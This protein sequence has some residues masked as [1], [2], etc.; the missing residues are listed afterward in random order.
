MIYV[1]T[2]DPARVGPFCAV[3]QEHLYAYA[4]IRINGGQTQVWTVVKKGR[5]RPAACDVLEQIAQSLDI[6]AQVWRGPLHFPE[7]EQGMKVLGSPWGSFIQQFL[8]MKH[9]TLLDRIPQLPDVQSAWS[10]LQLCVCESQ[11]P[12]RLFSPKQ[13]PSLPICTI[14]GSGIVCVNCFT[15]THHR[16]RRSSSLHLFRWD[17]VDWVS[18]MRPGPVCRHIGPAGQT[19]SQ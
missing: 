9:R 2:P 16:M 3:M 15:S 7:S 19:R 8:L 1:V 5:T 11:Q 17:W 18:A 4:R 13:L 6:D 12:L 14:N 10:L